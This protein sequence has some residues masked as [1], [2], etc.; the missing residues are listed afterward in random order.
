MVCTASSSHQSPGTRK[1]QTRV[2]RSIQIQGRFVQWQALD[3]TWLLTKSGGNH[4]Q[5]QRTS[6]CRNSGHRR[7]VSA[8]ESAATRVQSVKILVEKQAWRQSWRLRVYK[9]WVWCQR[10][11]DLCKLLSSPSWK[12]QKRRSSNSCESNWKKFLQ[13]R[14][15]KIGDHCGRSYS[16]L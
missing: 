2:Q 16:S 1:G 13:G 11:S 14:F 12:L 15:C 5:L 9:A 6:N 10:Q 8:S 3:G 4:F 7:N